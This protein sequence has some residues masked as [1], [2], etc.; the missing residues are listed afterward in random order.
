MRLYLAM[1]LWQMANNPTL[2]LRMQQP[3]ARLVAVRRPI[4]QGILHEPYTGVTLAQG[5]HGYYER[6]LGCQ[7]KP[8]DLGK[9]EVS[10]AP[11]DNMIMKILATLHSSMLTWPRLTMQ[12]TSYRESFNMKCKCATSHSTY[13]EITGPARLHPVLPHE[14]QPTLHPAIVGPKERRVA[15]M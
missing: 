12:E 6:G 7:G 14:Y 8:T 4:S 10:Q 2:S 1:I 5:I 9:M 15:K 11:F 3:H 13:R